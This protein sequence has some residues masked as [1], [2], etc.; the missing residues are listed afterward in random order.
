MIYTEIFEKMT[1]GDFYHMI[2]H[3]CELCGYV[4]NPSEGD[5]ENGIAENTDFEDLPEEWFCPLCGASKEDFTEEN[6][7]DDEF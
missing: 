2:H 4:Y 1:K 3:V 7:E 5:P 6:I